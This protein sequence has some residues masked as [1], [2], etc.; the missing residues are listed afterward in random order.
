[1]TA[2]SR[3]RPTASPKLTGKLYGRAAHDEHGLPH[4]ICR[5]FNAYGAGEMPEAEPGIANAL[6]DLIRRSLAGMRPLPIFGFNI[7]ASD[8]L[9]VAEIARLCWEACGN[10]PADFELEH[11]PSFE[12]DVHREKAERLLGWRAQID[13]PTEAPGPQ[14]GCAGRNGSRRSEGGRAVREACRQRVPRFD[15]S[16]GLPCQRSRPPRT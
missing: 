3:S 6:P 9:T 15:W 14:L 1:M 8:E 16:E 10:N 2:P 4:T 13:V 7:S 12:V 11:L 5:P